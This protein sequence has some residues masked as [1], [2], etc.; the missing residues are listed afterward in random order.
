MLR[1]LN[2]PRLLPIRWRGVVPLEHAAKGRAALLLLLVHSN[3]VAVLVRLHGQEQRDEANNELH[4]SGDSVGRSNDEPVGFPAAP[5]RPIQNLKLGVSNRQLIGSVDE[6]NADGRDSKTDESGTTG[7][8]LPR[9]SRRR[10]VAKEYLLAERFDKE[11]GY[12][13][14]GEVDKGEDVAK[15]GVPVCRSSHGRRHK[16]FRNAKKMRD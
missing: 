1:A 13:S 15:D 12:R 2:Y 4:D 16:W 9:M 10:R 11:D 3:I 7:E 8:V 6:Q 14:V 5:H